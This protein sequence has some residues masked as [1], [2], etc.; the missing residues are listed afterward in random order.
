MFED[1]GKFLSFNFQPKVYEDQLDEDIELFRTEDFKNIHL[2]LNQEINNNQ[3]EEE[4]QN[5]FSSTYSISDNNIN[6]QNIFIGQKREENILNEEEKKEERRKKNRESA[7]RSRDKKKVEI[8]NIFEQN[9]QLKK[10][11]EFLKKFIE[12]KTCETCKHKIIKELG[13]KKNNNLNIV[14]EENN[15]P[16]NIKQKN[17]KTLPLFTTL[18]IIICLYTT[19]INEN[20]QKIS[21]TISNGV[22][23]ISRNLQEYKKNFEFT[24]PQTDEIIM[25]VLDYYN[26]N[27]QTI[28]IL[29]ENYKKNYP[30][31]KF[32]DENEAY[33]KF[34]NDK[35]CKNCMV[36]LS[37]N[38]K[39]INSTNPT[40]FKFFITKN[41]MIENLLDDEL[42]KLYDK[43]PIEVVCKIIKIDNLN[44]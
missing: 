12:K 7:K 42:K 39:F 5:N 9:K 30:N 6:N 23:K 21:P 11:I 8:N 25:N 18:L 15:Q 40:I 35:E 44:K 16:Q 26:I 13:K 43:E 27:Y 37:K 36:G 4:N 22:E 1:I 29:Q 33:K 34:L 32:I 19:G 3:S 24:F 20:F 38:I 10:Q 31:V 17:S 41:N 14:I 2:N 28:K